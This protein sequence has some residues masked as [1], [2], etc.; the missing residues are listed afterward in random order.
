MSQHAGTSCVRVATCRLLLLLLLLYFLFFTLF[1]FFS[2]VVLQILPP[3]C[4]VRKL[5]R[6]H[7]KPQAGL[8]VDQAK[9]V[10]FALF[11]SHFVFLAPFLAYPSALAAHTSSSLGATPRASLHIR[12]IFC[13]SS[14]PTRTNSV[15]PNLHL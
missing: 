1:F 8:R 5:R 11:A 4:E 14:N 12:S 10:P 6:F 7:P 13:V 9:A 15:P 2:A 3:I